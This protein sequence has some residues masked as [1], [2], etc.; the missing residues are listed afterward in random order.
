[1]SRPS[2][3]DHD[4][5]RDDA[6]SGGEGGRG[7]RTLVRIAVAVGT[8][9]LGLLVTAGVALALLYATRWIQ[10]AIYGAVY[11]RLGP[12]DATA[13]ASLAHVL[14]VSAA[15]VGVAGLA[16]DALDTRLTNGRA[17]ATAG[18]AAT[19][20]VGAAWLLAAV[21]GLA[22]L[23]VA[24]VLLAVGL[25]A[26]PIAL[27]VADVRSGGTLAIAGGAPVALALL[28]VA[29]VGLGWGWG[30]VAVA[31]EVPASA[32]NATEATDFAAA[33]GFA[34]DLL[35]PANC[36]VDAAGRRVCR[37]ELRG[38]PHEV[39]AARF[40]ARHGVRCP[41]QGR[42]GESA[43]FLARAQDRYYRVT[44]AAHGD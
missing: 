33:P 16:G 27:H 2:T 14:V 38:S 31:Q 42:P 39:S 28:L 25:A 34:A 32:A 22:A 6:R 44:C 1:M 40:M 9:V 8:V 24:F 15:A 4:D 11:W 26:V 10:P 30:Y 21:V 20:G 41:Y 29:G 7:R 35:D 5:G 13:T 23:P 18:V 17:Y 37:L 12:S 3:D 19:V 43:S 36:E